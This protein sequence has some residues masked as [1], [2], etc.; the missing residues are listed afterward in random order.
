ME[1]PC[2]PYLLLLLALLFSSAVLAQDPGNCPEYEP[3]ATF[4]NATGG[5]NWKNNFGWL[6]NTCPCSGPPI[7]GWDG[8]SCD[9]GNL[10]IMFVEVFL[11]FFL[12][13]SHTIPSQLVSLL[14][15]PSSSTLAGNNLVGTLPSGVFSKL[16]TIRTM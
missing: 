9:N 5:P 7:R 16:T 10:S 8:L 12:L 11:F 13:F 3:L 14:V 1:G 2:I 4:F 15:L 6:S